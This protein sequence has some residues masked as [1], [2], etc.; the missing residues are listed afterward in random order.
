M[1]KVGVFGSAAGEETDQAKTQAR[2]IGEKLGRLKCVVI[3]GACSG[4][5]YIAA[6][7][8]HKSGAAIWGFSPKLGLE[9]QKAFT[10]TDDLKIYTKLIYVSKSFEFYNQD[11][12]SKKY[13]NV[14]S[15]ATCDAGI[16]IAG[17]WGTMNEFTNLFDMGKV[18]GV[19]TGTGGM[20]DELPRLFQK[21][22]KKSEAKV[23]FNDSPKE[24]VHEVVNELEERRKRHE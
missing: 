19:L 14:L 10:P 5:P 24:L 7:A 17:R 6:E 3:T 12:V 18:V 15:T 9:G 11:L 22:S 21:I 23:F 4:L 20:A 2:E 8:A 13:R 16:I 1:Y